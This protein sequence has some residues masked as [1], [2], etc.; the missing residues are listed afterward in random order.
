MEKRRQNEKRVLIKLSQLKKRCMI[1]G[2]FE[3]IIQHMWKR[4]QRINRKNSQQMLHEQNRSTYKTN[5]HY[6][7]VYLSNCTKNNW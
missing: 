2:N 6:N 4:T 5:C 7:C 1:S 3:A